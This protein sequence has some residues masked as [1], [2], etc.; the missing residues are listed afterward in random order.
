MGTISEAWN[1]SL[2]AL[3]PKVQNPDFISQFR[4][5]GLCNVAY[6][7]VTKL[8]VLRLCSLI[9]DLISPL[10][11]S[12]IPGRKGIDNVLILREFVYS[13]SKKIG[14]IG[15]MIIKIDLEKAYDRLEWSFVRE[16][17]IF[18]NFPPILISIIM[19]CLSSADFAIVINGRTSDSFKPSRGLRQGD[20]LSPYLFMLCV[21]FLSMKL[22]G[23]SNMRE[24]K[25]TKLGK[26]GPI[27]SHLFFAD[28]LIFV[29]KAS[30]SNAT[31]LENL[32]AFFCQRSSQKINLSKSKILFSHNV[33][34]ETKLNICAKLNIPE[35]HSLGKYL[36]FPISPKRLSKADCSFI[37]D[38]VRSKLTSWKAGMLSK[39]GRVT[40]ASSV[41]S[42]IPNY[43]MQ[44]AY[45]PE[46]IHKE[47]DS[48][49][50][51]FIWGST[52]EKRKTHLVS[53]DRVTQPKK[54][55]GLGLRSSKEANQALMAKV[56]WRMIS[57]KDRLWSKA[58]CEKYK[59]QDPKSDF[60]KASP[61]M[62]NI[63]KGN[64][65]LVKGV[66]WIPHSGDKILFWTDFW[67]GNRPLTDLLF[68][69]FTP[70]SLNQ[71]I[72]DVCLPSG[73]WKWE[74][75][76]YPLPFDLKQQIMA[77]PM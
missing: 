45:L 69:P 41:L 53:W 40:L 59:I 24:W 10:Q 19:S 47:L 13:F 20:P 54:L 66:K 12:F 18:F 73:Q 39:A 22:Q 36:G 52:S 6:K 17:L 75:I 60:K 33:T 31:Y 50:G 14:R 28:D 58:F 25:G 72:K 34:V 29:G 9:G 57:E 1:A 70:D 74:E 11:A 77:I 27:I 48:L 21:K 43:Y 76:A 5:I 26:R 8:I 16:A 37:V 68:G 71:K 67:V 61:V 64:H 3:I 63:A 38:K 44:G 32:L 62:H 56:Q 46:S 42:T 55:G 65:I 2:I 23:D 51:Q 4:P 35:T 30:L 7:I 49:T 15:D